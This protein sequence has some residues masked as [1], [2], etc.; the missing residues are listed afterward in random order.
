MDQIVCDADVLILTI[1]PEEN[2]AVFSE[3]EK[4]GKASRVLPTQGCPNQYEWHKF[5]L[6]STAGLLTIATGVVARAGNDT[7]Q[8]AVSDGLR[9]FN[10]AALLVVGVAGGLPK[11]SDP[12]HA[13]DV[14]IGDS[15]WSVDRGKIKSDGLHSRPISKIGGLG[16]LPGMQNRSNWQ[17]DWDTGLV[18]SNNQ[19]FQIITGGIAASNYVI[20]V[21][22]HELMREIVAVSGNAIRAV[23][24]ES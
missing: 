1:V 10:P 4:Y 5:L 6:P 14:V 9:R 20:T 16:L 18:N 17:K 22:D 21:T 2:S 13:G 11:D 7:M 24:M 8:A 23:E 15:V 12:M 19:P 3:L